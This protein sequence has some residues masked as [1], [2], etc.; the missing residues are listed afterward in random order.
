LNFTFHRIFILLAS[1]YFVVLADNPSCFSQ[2]TELHL[3]ALLQGVLQPYLLTLFC[4]WQ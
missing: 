4:Q 1:I 3:L 2:N